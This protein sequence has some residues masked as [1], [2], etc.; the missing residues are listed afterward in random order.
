MVFIKQLPIVVTSDTLSFPF[1][2]KDAT[3]CLLQR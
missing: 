2:D 3:A 1:V